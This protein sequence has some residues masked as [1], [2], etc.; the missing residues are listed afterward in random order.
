MFEQARGSRVS[1]CVVALMTALGLGGCAKDSPT[2]PSQPAAPTLT[3]PA[4]ESPSDDQQLTTLQ[5]SLR[6]SNATATPSGVRTYEFQVSSNEGFTAVVAST[7]NVA[8]GADGKTSW[9][10]A[11]G[12]QPTTRY[13]WRARAVQSATMG[14]WSAASRFRSKVE[15]YIR[16]GELYDPLANGET[17]GTARG[18]TFVAGGARFE[19]LDSLITYLLPQTLT[20]GEFSAK[21]SGI[22]TNSPGDRT[23]I[24]SMQEGQSDITDN[25]FRATVEKR[26]SGEIS[27]RFIS[28][29]PVDGVVNA[30]RQFLT[31]DPAMTYFWRLTWGNGQ[32]AMLIAEN[33]QNG[34]VLFAQTKG[35][36]GSYSPNP[37]FAYVGAPIPRGGA[38]G[39]SL[40]G[41]IVRDVW[42]AATSRPAGLGSALAPR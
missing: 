4:V 28:G 14:P 22:T 21:V 20:S 30:D 38:D 37:H 3:A 29:D 8:E 24:L 16:A 40:P 15:G 36:S 19:G 7:Q 34:R 41:M 31:F 17:V 33:D 6:L 9:T 32:V 18:I 10:V 39:A 35:Y 42:L 25:R 12:L 26:F 23:K 11:S 27:F 2:Q 5:P 13:W 1:V